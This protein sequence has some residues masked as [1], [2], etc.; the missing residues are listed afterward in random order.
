MYRHSLLLVLFMLPS[1]SPARADFH[2][3]LLASG[4]VRTEFN[5]A[6][7]GTASNP[8][9][10]GPCIYPQSAV[11]GNICGVSLPPI[12]SQSNRYPA[13]RSITPE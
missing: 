10:Y 1:T 8:L 13:S 2:D 3:P 11:N 7:E 9:T 4:K 5:A 6:N 12:F